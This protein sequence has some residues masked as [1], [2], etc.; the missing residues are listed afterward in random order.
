MS[1]ISE[2]YPT[3]IDGNLIEVNKEIFPADS[4]HK[5][6][7]IQVPK[8]LQQRLNTDV[9]LIYTI[10]ATENSYTHIFRTSVFFS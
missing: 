10:F 6:R 9:S 8:N 1:N 3:N 4:P 5:K 7:R 2:R